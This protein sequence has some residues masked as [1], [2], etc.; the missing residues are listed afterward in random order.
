MRRIAACLPLLVRCLDH[1]SFRPYYGVFRDQAADETQGGGPTAPF[2]SSISV[3]HNAHRRHL[4]PFVLPRPFA[5]VQGSYAGSSFPSIVVFFRDPA[6]FLSSLIVSE[7]AVG[8]NATLPRSPTETRCDP[9][10]NVDAIVSTNPFSVVGQRASVLGKGSDACL[11]FRALV[12][13]GHQHHVFPFFPS[14]DHVDHRRRCELCL[15]HR[16]RRRPIK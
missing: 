16:T 2:C 15:N 8:R 7:S 13:H 14:R 1:L 3:S 9:P 6:V 4:F 5:Q 12:I 10:G 11:V